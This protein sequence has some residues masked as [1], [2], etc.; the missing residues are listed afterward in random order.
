MILGRR[1]FLAGLGAMLAAPAIVHAGNLMPIS[2]AH[3]VPSGRTIIQ[4][5]EYAA[6]DTFRRYSGYEML[7]IS[8]SDF[9]G[10]AV[11]EDGR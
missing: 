4:T 2:A 1:S 8:A 11:F 7:N 6:P 3:L 9:Y 5:L 10:D